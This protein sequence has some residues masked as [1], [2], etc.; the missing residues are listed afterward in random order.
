[1][2]NKSA[3]PGLLDLSPSKRGETAERTEP[4]TSRDDPILQAKKHEQQTHALLRVAEKDS[5]HLQDGCIHDP[6]PNKAKGE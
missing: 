6:V 5:D 4:P 1:M 2:S 3:R